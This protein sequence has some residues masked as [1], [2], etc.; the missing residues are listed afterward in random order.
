MWRSS[1][2]M[3]ICWRR[4]ARPKFFRHTIQMRSWNSINWVQKSSCVGAGS[5]QNMSKS[6]ICRP[7]SPEKLCKLLLDE[8]WCARV[9]VSLYGK[10][11]FHECIKHIQLSMSSSMRILARESNTYTLSFLCMAIR[12]RALFGRKIYLILTII[13][14]WEIFLKF[15]YYWQFICHGNGTNCGTGFIIGTWMT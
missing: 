12:K 6:R 7:H 10:I 1:R 9:L 14:F 15:N 2:S 13:R 8:L 11:D 5:P 4:Y 3:A